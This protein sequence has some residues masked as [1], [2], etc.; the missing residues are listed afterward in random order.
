MDGQIAQFRTRFPN[1]GEFETALGAQGMTAEGFAHML[2]LE[3]GMKKLVEA[4]ILASIKIS[5]TAK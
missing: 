5:E 1:P 3:A 2:A 4:E